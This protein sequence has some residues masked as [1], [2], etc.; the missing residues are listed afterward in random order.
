MVSIRWNQSKS[1]LPLD[2]L[3]EYKGQTL[4]AELAGQL[5]EL[6]DLIE[7]L[8]NQVNG[9]MYLLFTIMRK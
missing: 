5:K 1:R 6:P 4:C 2:G 9:T 7:R 8:Q 3:A